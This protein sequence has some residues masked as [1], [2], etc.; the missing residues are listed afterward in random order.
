MERVRLFDRKY[1]EQESSSSPLARCGGTSPPPPVPAR[2]KRLL[3]SKKKDYASSESYSRF[4]TQPITV[5]EVQEASRNIKMAMMQL[6]Q[7]TASV[8][9]SVTSVSAV[10]IASEG[11][12]RGANHDDSTRLDSTH[13]KRC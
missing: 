4:Q 10:K 13:G 8:M 11:L 2:R 9:R 12:N 6:Q 5:D 3:A 7:T 1:Q